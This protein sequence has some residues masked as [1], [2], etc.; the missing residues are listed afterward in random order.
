MATTTGMWLPARSVGWRLGVAMAAEGH[1]TA[2]IDR[3][4]RQ[5]MKLTAVLHTAFAVLVGAGFLVSGRLLQYGLFALGVA[6]FV[7]GIVLAR[8]DGDAS[9]SAGSA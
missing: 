6:C 7:A 4:P 2:F 3:F 9:E 5:G 1:P 8:R